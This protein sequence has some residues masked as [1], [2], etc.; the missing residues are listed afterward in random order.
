MDFTLR[1]FGRTIVWFGFAISLSTA[2]AATF[3]VENTALNGAGSLK[4]AIL[5]ANAAAGPDEIVFNIP[6]DGPHII[7]PTFQEFLPAITDRVTINGYSQPGAQPNTGTT[8]NNAV[9]KIQIDGVEASANHG[10]T[11]RASGNVIRG[12]S[13]TRFGGD[14]I[15]IQSGANNNTIAGNFLGINALASNTAEAGNRDGILMTSSSGNTIGG[16]SPADA[17]LLSDNSQFG[18]YIQSGATPSS[19]NVIIGNWLGLSANGGNKGNSAG[20]VKVF[21]SQRTRIGGNAAGERNVVSGNSDVGFWVEGSTETL[22]QG[23]YIGTDASGLLARANFGGGILIFDASGNRVVGNAISGNS[24]RGIALDG[25]A[26]DNAILN[27]LIGVNVAG[28]ALRNNSHG[29]YL[30]SSPS[31]NRI[32]D[33]TAN[34]ANTIANNGGAGIWVSGGTGNAI[35]GNSIHSNTGLGI[36]L[37]DAGPS[38]GDEGDADTGANDLQNF[39]ILNEATVTRTSATVRGILN[40]KTLS[41]FTIDFY[42]TAGTDAEGSIWIG[43][44][45][46]TTDSAGNA[47]FEQAIPAPN[48][49]LLITATATDAQG[50]SSEF[51]PGLN[52]RSFVPAREFTVTTAADSGPGSFRQ[53]LL[54]VNS[55]FSFDAIRFAI[56]G[57]GT[58]VI[59]VLSP[60]PEPQDELLIDG[61]SQGAQLAANDPRWIEL[62]GS[63]LSGTESGLALGNAG[64]VRGLGFVNFPGSALEAAGTQGLRIEGNWIGVTS[65]RGAGPNAGGGIRIT[66]GAV[67]V[68]GCFVSGNLASGIH[69]TGA[70]GNTIQGNWIGLRPATTGLPTEALPNAE[71]GIRIE[72]SAANQIGGTTAGSGNIVSGNGH[73]GIQ[74]AGASARLNRV[75][76]NTIG[77]DNATTRRIGNQRGGILITGG[78]SQTMVG[79]TSASSRNCIAHNIGHGVWVESGSRN[80]ILGNVMPGNSMK[81]IFISPGAN[82]GIQQPVITSATG[83]GGTILTAYYEAFTA[84]LKRFQAFTLYPFDPENPPPATQLS[85]HHSS[86]VTVTAP[87]GTVNVNRTYSDTPPAGSQIFITATERDNTSAS[88]VT[89]ITQPACDVS[90]T[91]SAPEEGVIRSEM[92]FTITVSNA[93]PATARGVVVEDF[94]PGTLVVTSAQGGTS[95]TYTGAAARWN[96]GDLA[97]GQSVTLTLVGYAS[98]TGLIRNRVTATTTSNDINL[99][100]N[101]HTTQ[102]FVML[103]AAPPIPK[104]VGPQRAGSGASTAFVAPGT[105]PI[106]VTSPPNAPAATVDQQTRVVIIPRPPGETAIVDYG[107]AIDEPEGTADITETAHVLF[108]PRPQITLNA[109]RQGGNI[110]IRATGLPPE[111][112]TVNGASSLAGPWRAIQTISSSTG[113]AEVFVPF[114]ND[115][116]GFFIN[117]Q[118]GPPPIEYAGTEFLFTGVAPAEFGAGSALGILA[119]PSAAT[120]I[121]VNANSA[122]SQTVNAASLPDEAPLSFYFSTPFRTGPIVTTQAKRVAADPS[123]PPVIMPIANQRAAV[124]QSFAPVVVQFS[125]ADN[126][127]D[128]LAINR[129][130]SDPGFLPDSSVQITREG[131]IVLVNIAP[132][133][134]AGSS[135]ITLTANDGGRTATANFRIA[136][137]PNPPVDFTRDGLPDILVAN[138]QGGIFAGSVANLTL[139]PTTL[140]SSSPV[141]QEWH[142]AAGGDFN[143]DNWPDVVFQNTDGTTATWYFAEGGAAWSDIFSPLTPNDAQWRAVAAGDFNADGIPELV[144]QLPA[145]ATAVAIGQLNAR[146]VSIRLLQGSNPSLGNRIA[147][148]GDFNADGSDDLLFQHDGGALAAWYLNGTTRLGSAS[149]NPSAPPATGARAVAGGDFNQNGTADLIFQN[150]DGGLALWF[151][152]GVDLLESPA[153]APPPGGGVWQV[154]GP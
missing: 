18:V 9:I 33:G 94:A 100:N 53:A 88:E 103:P 126:L 66:G 55:E 6:G 41:A 104:G 59:N 21:F 57:A 61:F 138:A 44:Q 102:T 36:D 76:G 29:I 39:P 145:P 84:E 45:Q 85:R 58:Q 8:A 151:M 124:G 136:V 16:T 67:T 52:L 122:F 60:L 87:P 25:S 150:P 81:P 75:E 111:V 112:V 82:E 46:L 137:G 35:R 130:S 134:Q 118:Q 71:S 119:P 26:N 48:N 40:S 149:L 117:L 95:T 47:P 77:T 132:P 121:L 83:G 50:N 123:N 127:I 91:K 152:N 54:D 17:N 80:S 12:L 97:S 68:T 1:F 139:T 38:A 92:T 98:D 51:S 43:S 141:S 78:A 154:L 72:N 64:T 109:R 20:G 101:E 135:V 30:G 56:P 62:N 37:G 110:A 146:G 24:G 23:N 49:L 147:T 27:N 3:T 79:T 133:A 93:G 148:T 153:I 65:A 131:G 14:A 90:V 34:G 125:D 120:R 28:A 115:A 107:I 10:L 2:P 143:A 105:G 19:D 15:N 11:L 69:V 7:A 114:E 106:T 116:G 129:Q 73:Y 4:Q 70:G 108:P 42:A 142:L 96:L 31:R 5:D 99:A 113:E 13:I 89:P 74:I 86:D 128:L 144:H 32:G 140:F 22:I 63:A